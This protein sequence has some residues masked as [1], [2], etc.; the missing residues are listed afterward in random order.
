MIPDLTFPRNT[1]GSHKAKVLITINKKVADV[2]VFGDVDVI[3]LN[4]DK[5]AI[6]WFGVCS[7][8]RF[9]E[10]V[11]LQ[12]EKLE[13]LT[14]YGHEGACL[15]AEDAIDTLNWLKGES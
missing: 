1:R 15:Y 3:L 5:D 8:E 4:Q 14:Y 6:S 10:V 12:I 11:D 9:D 13:E 7:K 2:A